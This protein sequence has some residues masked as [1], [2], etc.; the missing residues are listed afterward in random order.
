MHLKSSVILLLTIF[1]LALGQFESLPSSACDFCKSITPRISNFVA[2]GMSEI[3]IVSKLHQGCAELE[4]ISG[5]LRQ[6]CDGFVGVYVDYMADMI[7]A[8]TDADEFCSSF[9]LCD[10]TAS[11]YTVLFP[12]IFENNVTYGVQTEIPATSYKYK[13][14]LGNSSELFGTNMVAVHYRL[15]IDQDQVVVMRI[16]KDEQIIHEV[17]CTMAENCDVMDSNPADGSWYFIDIMAQDAAGQPFK[18]LFNATEVKWDHHTT[19]VNA[20]RH[21]L[22][23][24]SFMLLIATIGAIS[25]LCASC[26]LRI[27]KGGLARS[28]RCNNVVVEQGVVEYSPEYDTQQPMGGYFYYFPE[29]VSNQMECEMQVPQYWIPVPPQPEPQAPTIDQMN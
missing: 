16:T 19:F 20:R 7:T 27:R 21:G 6:Q 12:S 17:E 3:D 25:C 11:E 28:R 1:G 15:T 22:S 29:Q 9:G 10:A 24:I 26:C 14:F 18:I 13:I 5:E 23:L 2:A 8:T 4:Q